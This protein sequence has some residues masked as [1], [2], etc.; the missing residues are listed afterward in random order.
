MR[1]LSA[2]VKNIPVFC[3]QN[4]VRNEEIIRRY[5]PRVYGVM[6]KAGAVFIA[7]VKWKAA[8]T[9]P[10]GWLSGVTRK[11]RMPW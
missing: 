5:F 6:L 3:F 2:A 10:A 7:R 1:D 9:H 11:A 8:A 4:G